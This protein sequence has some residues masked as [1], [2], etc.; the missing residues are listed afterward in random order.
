PHQVTADWMDWPAEYA[1]DGI[2][3]SQET[4]SNSVASV[5]RSLDSAD[6]RELQGFAYAHRPIEASWAALQRLLRLASP[7]QLPLLSRRLLQRQSVAHIVQECGLHGQKAWLQAC[8][9]EV[10]A[11]LQSRGISPLG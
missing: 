2:S 1:L 11:Y 8:R 5:D 9:Q 7:G 4:H 6:W 3:H 10:A